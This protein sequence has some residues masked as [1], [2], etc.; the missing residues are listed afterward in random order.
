[1][2][3]ELYAA[4]VSA[5]AILILIPGPNVALI[6][7]T[8]ISRGATRGMVIVAGTS[9][10]MALQ[11]LLTVAGLTGLLAALASWFELLRWLGVAYLVH[12]G[13]KAWRAPER[14]S[15]ADPSASKSPCELFMR[16]FFVSLTNPK[17]L[18]FYAAFLP[19]FIS[20]ASDPHSQL[21]V[22]A[23]TF[24]VIAVVLDSLWALLAHK[25][26]HLLGISG[27]ALNRVTGG[28]LLTAAAGL[29]LARRP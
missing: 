15:A 16:G 26:R 4:F 11:L 13:L 9:S 27:R 29:A 2:S 18:L 17:T 7:A 19:Q 3:I 23:G 28:L 10:A 12:L 8:S 24:L 21:I 25:M 20:P 1:M 6:V 5:T 22:L 14:V